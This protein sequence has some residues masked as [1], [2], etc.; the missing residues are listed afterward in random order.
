MNYKVV[1]LNKGKEVPILRRHHWIFGGAIKKFPNSFEN[2]E[3]LEVRDSTNRIVGYGYFNKQT[4]IAGRMISYGQRDPIDELA[5]RIDEAMVLRSTLFNSKTNAFRLINGE[6]DGI[7]GL[8][9]DKYNDVLVIQIATAGIN[10]L[11]SQIVDLLINRLKPRSIYEK[12]VMNSRKEEG[13]KNFEDFL[14]ESTNKDLVGESV[15]DLKSEQVEILEN[16]I[17]FRIN[18]KN[19][20][21]T[22]FYLDQR[23]MRRLIGSLSPNKRV[24]NCFSYTGG[25]S[26]YAAKNMANVVTSVDISEEVI[27][28]AKE[29]FEVNQLNSSNYEFIAQDVFDYLDKQKKLDYDIVILDP[30][31]FAKKKK[32]LEAAKKGYFRLN[33]E[34]LKKMKPGS[35]LLTCSCSY[36]VDQEA[37]EE[38]ILRAASNARR[39]VRIIQRHRHAL[40]HVINIY[41]QEMDYLKSLVL[42]VE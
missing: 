42:W 17:K 6:G 31:A 3:I 34:T 29:N 40:D 36:H 24:L 12:S 37:F 2:G 4:T 13:L 26:V 32:D 1:Y 25:F 15:G 28:Q 20:H 14:F 27:A 39:N 10:R 22:G 30:P 19:S 21:K 23:E 7:P 18:L 41:H 16:G 9:V 35:I 5:K 33:S 11:R 8:I 38:I